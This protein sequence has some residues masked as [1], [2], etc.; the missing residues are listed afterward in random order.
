MLP[1]EKPLATI[2][3]DVRHYDYCFGCGNSNPAGLK[4]SFDW[5]GKTT[6]AEFIP[7]DIHQGWPNTVHGGLLCAILDEA[8]GWAARHQGIDGVTGKMEA[9]L[10]QPISVGQRV[11]ITSTVTKITRKL[12]KTKAIMTLPNDTVAAE[13]F[14]TIYILPQ[15]RQAKS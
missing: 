7:R 13:A 1:W 14:G 5:D 10:K 3:L 15:S 9:R 4:L 6:T 2:N 12:V 8:L 11:H